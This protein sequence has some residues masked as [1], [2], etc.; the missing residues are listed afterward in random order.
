MPRQRLQQLTKKV[1]YMDF[2][3]LS[4]MAKDATCDR[5]GGYQSQDRCG[6]GGV[7]EDRA[8]AAAGGRTVLSPRTTSRMGSG[9]IGAIA[10]PPGLPQPMLEDQAPM[11]H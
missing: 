5:R 4:T 8:L 10:S 11:G 3:W 7:M 9:W 1:S 6:A 2:S